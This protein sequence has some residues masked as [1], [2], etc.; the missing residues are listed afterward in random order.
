[1]VMTCLGLDSFDKNLFSSLFLPDHKGQFVFLLEKISVPLSIGDDQ[2]VNAQSL[3]EKVL[4]EL[5]GF[6]SKIGFGLRVFFSSHKNRGN[7]QA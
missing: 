1:M 2:T 6:F 5:L 3:P 4:M 7:C